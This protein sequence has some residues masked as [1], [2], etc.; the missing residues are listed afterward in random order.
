MNIP[1]F[2]GTPAALLLLAASLGNSQVSAQT[3]PDPPAP[4]AY[5][6][7]L[8]GYQS[9]TD[10]KVVDWKEANDN[11]GRIAGWREYA[12]E[13]AEAQTPER[14]DKPDPG[15]APAQPRREQP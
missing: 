8:E 2:F 12:K 3:F 13:A 14:A 15:A 1:R 5:R 7:A 6:S 11:T 10:E 4:P 9:Y